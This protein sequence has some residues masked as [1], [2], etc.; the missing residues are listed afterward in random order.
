M[1]GIHLKYDFLFLSEKSMTIPSH[2]GF[3]YKIEKSTTI[4]LKYIWKY[5][6]LQ[7]CG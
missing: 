2:V 7:T 6:L 3:I 5:I 1:T 4:L